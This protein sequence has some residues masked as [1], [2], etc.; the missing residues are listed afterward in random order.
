VS[1]WRQGR[2][3]L[4]EQLIRRASHK[5][6]KQLS[7]HQN[8]AALSRHYW[9]DEKKAPNSQKSYFKGQSTWTSKKC[10]NDMRMFSM[11]YLLEKLKP[12][13]ARERRLHGTQGRGDSPGLTGVSCWHL[14][15]PEQ[16]ATEHWTVAAKDLDSV[17]HRHS[18]AL[19]G[20]T[21]QQDAR[22]SLVVG[23]PSPGVHAQVCGAPAEP[24]DENCT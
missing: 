2:Q 13:P 23:R 19:S 5:V 9:A 17:D 8:Q 18:E 12:W 14:W 11:S 21:L 7:F 6:L 3:T 20:M 10:I 22:P 1:S 16:E 4:P 15:K 24:R